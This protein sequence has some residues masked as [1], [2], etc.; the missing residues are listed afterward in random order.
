MV[1]LSDYKVGASVAV[2]DMKTARAFYEGALRLRVSIDSGDNVAYECAGGTMIHIFTSPNAGNATATLAGWGVDDVDAMVEE[3]TRQGV[4]FEVYTEGPI[5]TD[6]KGVAT[7]EGGA[8][9]AVLQGSRGQHPV[10]RARAGDPTVVAAGRRGRDPAACPRP[11]SS[12]QV[13]RGEARSRAG[14]GTR[15]RRALP[16]W[17]HVLRAVR[18]V[19][20]ALRRPYAD[21]MGSRRHRSR[22]GGPPR[23][24]WCSRSTTC[25]GCA[26][27]GASP[28][29]TGTTPR[30]ASVSAAPGSETA[31]AICSVSASPSVDARPLMNDRSNDHA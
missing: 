2:S 25:R 11:R 29:S 6:A 27:S 18:V 4:T 23:V 21:G 28:T 10:D 1:S 9:V 15:G 12:T 8:K 13:L 19:R 31:K 16:L 17:Q 22:R 24:V 26:R 3:L 14:R 7:F 20:R 5:I 30:K